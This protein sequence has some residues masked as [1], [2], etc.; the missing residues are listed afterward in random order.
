LNVGWVQ[1]DQM[2]RRVAAVVF[3]LVLR[4]ALL[5]AQESVLTVSVPTAVVHKGPSTV[6]PIVGHVSRGT[7]LPVSQ[8][9]GSWVKVSWPTAP[10]GVGYVHATMG[11]VEAGG[12][13]PGT[14]TASAPF[15]AP[16]PGVASTAP[17]PTGQ[18]LPPAPS[19]STRV[20][21]AFGVGGL[22]APRTVGATVRSWGNRHLGI[23]FRFTREAMTSA[24]DASRATST[25][26]E[27]GVIYAPFDHVSDYVWFRPYVGTVTSFR[28]QT[29]SGAAL[30]AADAGSASGLG[31]RVFG[32]S[33]LVLASLPRFGV[34][35]EVGYR[36]FPPL[37]DGFLADRLS[38][39][40]AGHW[41]IK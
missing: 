39:S 16:A 41:Y 4:T 9:L 2:T 22:V 15:S 21:H 40:I 5:S 29:L 19:R 6:T 10:D 25:V 33:E 18:M 12:A 28:R 26:F 17:R 38:G 3:M 24:I 37:F 8:N 36:R 13:R 23:Q 14:G 7:A 20:P 1:E 30:P 31:Y 34:S 27:P 32:G 35:V 11:R